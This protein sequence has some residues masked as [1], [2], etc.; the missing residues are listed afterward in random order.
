MSRK[1]KRYGCKP[2]LVD[3]RD[4]LF[5]NSQHFKVMQLPQSGDLTNKFPACWDQ[6]NLGCCTGHG[7]VG[8]MVFIHPNQMFSRLDAYYNG[9]VIEGDVDQDNGAQIRDVVSGLANV[10][11]VEESLW[12][13]DITTFAHPPVD[14]FDKASSYRI[15]QYLRCDGL[16]DVKNSL[17]Q[18]F[19]VIIGFSVYD[20]FESTDM[21]KTGILHLPESGD[22]MIGGHCVLV[23]GY[24]DTKNLAKIRNSWGTGWGP[25]DGNF[26]MDYGY[27]DQLVSDCWTIRQ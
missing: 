2:D 22:Q 4:L 1:I 19:P 25:F 23:I 26:F 9:R 14:S 10:G 7:S 12:P 5:R 27:F 21:E 11:V 3:N 18:G 8:A 15:S 13:Y 24:D 17:A 16:G 6:G 20:N